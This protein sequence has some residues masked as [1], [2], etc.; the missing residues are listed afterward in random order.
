MKKL[1]LSEELTYPNTSAHGVDVKDFLC[2]NKSSHRVEIKKSSNSSYNPHIDEVNVRKLFIK[3]P[4]IIL[5][6]HSE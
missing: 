6:V 4:A 1:K 3:G 2:L 5:M